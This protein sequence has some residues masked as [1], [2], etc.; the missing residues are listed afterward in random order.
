MKIT[1]DPHH[2]V[3]MWTNEQG[4]HSLPGLTEE[5]KYLA[6]ELKLL[7]FLVLCKLQ[8]AV[9]NTSPQYICEGAEWQG[10]R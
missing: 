8:A 9:S 4:P 10:Q 5:V 6:L 2:T 1:N 3:I 7:L